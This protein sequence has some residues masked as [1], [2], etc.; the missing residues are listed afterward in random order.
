MR[1]VSRSAWPVWIAAFAAF[2]AVAV[3][4]EFTR[5][6]FADPD[7]ATGYLLFTLMV[8]LALYSSRKRLSMIPA[9]RASI[10]LTLHIVVG[11]LALALFWMHIRTLWPLGTVDQVLAGLFYAVCASGIVGYGLQLWLPGRLARA[12]GREIIYERIPGEIAEIRANV[13]AAILLAAEESGYDT[14]GRYYLQTLAWYFARPRFFLSHAFGGRRAEYWF[15]R[16]LETIERYLS[17]AERRHLA[18]I[19]ELGVVKR[20]ADAQYAM[21]SLLKRWTHVHVP[22]A[23]ALLVF[24]TWHLVLVHVFAR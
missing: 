12:A 8:F 24:A 13:E 4:E 11:L 5:R 19:S 2:A 10:W 17:E 23:A 16:H 21:Q 14:L 9:G 15:R 6:T 3:W 18:R 7:F 22:L 1:V 20:R